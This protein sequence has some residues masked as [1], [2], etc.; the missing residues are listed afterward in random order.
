H[1]PALDADRRGP[2][3]GPRRARHPRDHAAE[4]RGGPPEA[5]CGEGL[6]PAQGIWMERG[7]QGACPWPPR[8]WRCVKPFTSC[9]VSFTD[10][11]FRVERFTGISG[12]GRAVNLSTRK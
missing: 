7:G 8:C 3:R 6:I 2:D 9:V 10:G 11:R 1:A 4:G 12:R 5:D